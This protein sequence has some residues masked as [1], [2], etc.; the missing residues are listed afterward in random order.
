VTTALWL[1]GVQGLLGA[2]DTVYY[3]EWRARLP[4]RASAM[5]QELRLH[6][7]RSLIYGVV[8]CTLPWFAWTGPFAIVL[9]ALLI[10]EAVIT[11]A[12]FLVEDRVRTVLGGV[13]PG[14]RITHGIIGVVYGAFLAFLVPVL[15]GWLAGGGPAPSDAAI[16]DL[17]RAALTVLG[18]GAALSGIRDALAA[19]GLRHAAWPWGV[20]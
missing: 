13:F 10:G 8:F 2:W 6:A 14:E 11:F 1:M 18:M 3:H 4:A 16:P 9:M 20:A 12:D 15:A 19:R 17:A 5:G 7:V